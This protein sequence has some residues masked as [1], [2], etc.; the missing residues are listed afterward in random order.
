M[1]KIGKCMED[2]RTQEVNVRSQQA[3]LSEN[4]CVWLMT[5]NLDPRFWGSILW[6]QQISLLIQNPHSESMSW[7]NSF[8]GVYHVKQI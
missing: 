7:S 3:N 8:K 1:R 4:D 6:L 5:K 2:I